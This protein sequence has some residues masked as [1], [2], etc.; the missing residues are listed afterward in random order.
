[1]E[2]YCRAGQATDDNMAHAHCMLDTYGYKHV[3]RIC[4]TCCFSTATTIAI[5]RLSVALYVRCV[6]HWFMPLASYQ[7][8][9]HV[10]CSCQFL[11]FQR[12]PTQFSFMEDSLTRCERWRVFR[13]LLPASLFLP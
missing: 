12:D 10:F 6:S 3:L 7:C 5:T 1:V 13:T 4:Y 2:Y 8:N 11:W 9:E